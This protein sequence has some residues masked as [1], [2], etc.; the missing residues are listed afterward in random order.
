MKT[1]KVLWPLIFSL[2]LGTGYAQPIADE[3]IPTPIV[4]Q[5][6]FECVNSG[7]TFHVT[8]GVSECIVVGKGHRT[9][10]CVVSGLQQAANLLVT[11]TGFAASSLYTIPTDAIPIIKNG[12]LMVFAGYGATKN[13][14][15]VFEYYGPWEPS[16]RFDMTCSWESP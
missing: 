4:P 5:R 9:V 14:R 6:Q 10:R 12:Q 7:D 11:E 13:S 15:I 3:L 8:E 2:F 1:K 16:Y